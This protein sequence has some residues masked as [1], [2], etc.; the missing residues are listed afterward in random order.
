MQTRHLRFV[1]FAARREK[2]I[3]AM[4]DMTP[5]GMARR[6]DSN[7]SKPRLLMMMP[8]KVMSPG[9]ISDRASGNVRGKIVA[10]L[11]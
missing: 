6:D 7:G 1:H 2:L 11:R 8:L 10:Y 9:I 5:V 3:D 4:V